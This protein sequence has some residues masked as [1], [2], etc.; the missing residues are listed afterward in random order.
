MKKGYLVSQN[1]QFRLPKGERKVAGWSDIDVF[2]LG[3]GESVIVS[4]KSG[5]G[6]KKSEEVAKDLAR[7][8]DNAFRFLQ[9]SEKYRLWVQGTRVRK[10]VIVDWSVPKA[11]KLLQEEGIEVKFYGD[12]LEELIGLLKEEID[13]RGK[14]RIG[15]EEDPLLR[16]LVA[17]ITKGFISEEK[18]SSLS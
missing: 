11:E 15:K 8:F 9:R 7:W 2:A 1:I 12:I 13:A 4:C 3:P 6:F 10:V 16:M 17:M 18:L 14:G 5:L